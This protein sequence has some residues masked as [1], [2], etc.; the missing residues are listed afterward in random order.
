VLAVGISCRVEDGQLGGRGNRRLP[1]RQEGGL[2]GIPAGQ[3]V[4]LPLAEVRVRRHPL[5]AHRAAQD[6]AGGGRGDAV[7]RRLRDG[8]LYGRRHAAEEQ[9]QQYKDDDWFVGD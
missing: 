2:V 4:E 1:Q 8:N 5:H 3:Q 6:R 9:G 7:G